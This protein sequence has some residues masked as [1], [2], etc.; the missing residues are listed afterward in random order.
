MSNF[1]QNVSVFTVNI[2]HKG[3]LVCLHTCLH[4]YNVQLIPWHIH[5][6][7]NYS[8]TFITQQHCTE[9]HPTL[10]FIHRDQRIYLRRRLVSVCQSNEVALAKH[11]M[12][13]LIYALRTNLLQ[14]SSHRMYYYSFR[15]NSLRQKARGM[16]P[17]VTGL[18]HLLM[19]PL[20]GGG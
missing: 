19:P 2:W 6:H 1:T 3:K 10:Q 16:R 9:T 20:F 14:T 12:T 5:F 17:S 11:H 8:C 15:S 13:A 7:K 18:S 4:M